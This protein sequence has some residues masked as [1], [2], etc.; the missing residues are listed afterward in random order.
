MR[1]SPIWVLA[2]VMGCVSAG[3]KECQL[4]GASTVSSPQGDDA[5]KPATA[6]ERAPV[7]NR[8]V[9]GIRGTH[10]TLNNEPTFLLGISYYGGLGAADDFLRRD[11]D[12]VRR[13]G[14]NWLRVWATCG[15]FGQDISVVDQEGHMREPRLEK[16][17]RIV[18]ECDRRGLVV[19]VT[20]TRAS[21]TP[22][23]GMPSLEPHKRAVEAIVI[24]LKEYRNWYLDLANERDVRDERFVPV[25]E[26]KTLREVVRRLDPARLVTASLGGHDVSDGDLRDSLQTAGLDFVT[27]HRPRDPESPAQTDAKT[28]E[29]LA[30]MK[31][32]GR[33][34]PVHYQE[35]LR[36][37]YVN[38]DPS[39][40]DILTDL[41]GALA[42]GA[43]GW[44]FH[45]GPQRGTKDDL[46]R[47]SFD[48]RHRRLFDQ[49][50]QQERI[51]VGRASA[52]VRLVHE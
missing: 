22:G 25:D 44:C 41:R 17:K 28:R 5:I 52:E 49:L 50:D 20:L 40:A 23:W 45:N 29:C 9:L 35:P 10:F 8:T 16:L 19:D 42:G 37:G 32:L 7:Q 2:I 14:F 48:L 18:A 24:A 43:A 3:A 13:H 36:R 51:V 12:D 34:A 47:R 39:A 4:P 33:V 6:D 27:P 21:K 46:P 11:L 31:K 26:L 30:M 1:Q 38:R 15:L